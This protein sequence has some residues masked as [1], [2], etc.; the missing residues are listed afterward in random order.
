M[1]TDFWLA[2][3]IGLFG[4][5]GGVWA[6]FKI[7]ADTK[8]GLKANENEAKRDMSVSWQAIATSLQSQV[9][10]IE[11]RLGKAFDRIDKQDARLEESDAKERKLYQH[12]ILLE[13]GYPP[14]VPPRPE[15]I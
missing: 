12:I 5:S 2:L 9:T 15:G 3:G 10:D 8:L 6:L 11:T 14:P 7:R 1:N 13:A 4:G